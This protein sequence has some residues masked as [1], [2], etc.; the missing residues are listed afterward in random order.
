MA[1]KFEKP[2]A[3]VFEAD[4]GGKETAFSPAMQNKCFLCGLEIG[5]ADPRQFHEKNGKLMLAHTGC[6]NRFMANGETWPTA[7]EAKPVPEV[8]DAGDSTLIRYGLATLAYGPYSLKLTCQPAI[9]E[10]GL[11]AVIPDLIVALVAIRERL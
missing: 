8:I 9:A 2:R 11:K 7:E 1:D 4:G 3:G 10:K 5:E 6:L